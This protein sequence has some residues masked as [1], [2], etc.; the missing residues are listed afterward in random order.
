MMT[1]VDAA[2]LD[3]RQFIRSGDQILWGQACGE[4][5][6]LTEALVAQ[7]AALG[8]ASV[9]LGSGFSKTLQPEHADHLT[10][11]GIGGIGTHR[12]LTASGKLAVLPCHVGQ[13]A[14]YI[15]AGQIRCD[16]VFVQVARTVHPDKFSFAA[17][18][19][20]V[21]EAIDKARVVVA[22]VND[23]APDTRCDKLL[24]R[25]RIDW[26]INTSRPLVSVAPASIGE[27]ERAIA[28]HASAFIHDGATLQI[29]VGAIPDAIAQLLVDR[30]NLGVHSG[31]LGDSVVDL[32]QA[33]AVNNSLKPIDAGIT[34]TGMLIGSQRLFDFAHRNDSIVLHPSHYTHGETTLAQLPNLV[35]VN[36]AL[37]VDLSGQSNAEQT[38]DDY[39]GG[40]GGQAD[41]VRAGNRSPGGHS[42]LAMPA[43]AL[44]GKV[45]RICAA[46]SGPV[47]NTRAEADIIVTEFGAAQLRCQSIPE[48]ARRLIA[49]AH[50]DFREKLAEQAARLL[51][52]GY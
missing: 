8:A 28:H 12:R 4:P 52:R 42:I 39:V 27:V 48:R 17:V 21:Q 1:V 33:G 26:L 29:G 41:Y 5:L 30:R 20:Y 6:T 35:T 43:T 18:N 49:I 37:E 38:G 10:F 24:A 23:M 50:P 36:T 51:Q 16:V 3:L 40:V 34:V 7:R 19:D 47:T 45:S 31:M 22:E 46:L 13:I 32:M 15:R 11:S 14:G 44:K 2:A 9:F 25:S